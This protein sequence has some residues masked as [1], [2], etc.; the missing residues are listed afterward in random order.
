MRRQ[1]T[2]IETQLFPLLMNQ[3]RSASESVD[4]FILDWRR[5]GRHR[6]SNSV[7]LK[8]K[9]RV[10]EFHWGGTLFQIQVR[11]SCHGSRQS[12]V[13]L[14]EIARPLSNLGTAEVET[15]RVQS[16]KDA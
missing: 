6:N 7:P 11:K 1:E 9:F 12:V 5:N 10:C 16:D 4:I 3:I 14:A 15:A 8:L 13:N 2:E